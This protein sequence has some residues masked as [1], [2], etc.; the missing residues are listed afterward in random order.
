MMF[1]LQ[2]MFFMQTY[3]RPI[4]G[5]F[6]SWWYNKQLSKA[7][8]SHDLLKIK[9]LILKGAD[10]NLSHQYFVSGNIINSLTVAIMNENTDM[11]EFLLSHGAD[12]AAEYRT[13]EDM[14]C[15]AIQGYLINPK[16]YQ[17]IIELLLDY[18]ADVDKLNYY[19]MTPIVQFLRLFRFHTNINQNDIDLL[20]LMLQHSARV[21]VQE[22]PQNT[23]LLGLEDYWLSQPEK[24]TANQKK[25]M[26]E[27]IKILK[28][29]NY[30]K[31]NAC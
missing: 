21:K 17:K 16:I 8:K 30:R 6:F 5:G 7:I 2:S 9:A 24:L 1:F 15:F 13:N 11:V 19:E 4:T 28:S 29:Y 26:Q 12:V 31:L 22:V 27:A 3:T 14:L 25:Y 20:K 18:G 10:V 23:A